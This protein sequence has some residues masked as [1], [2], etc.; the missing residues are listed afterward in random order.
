MIL[1][2]VPYIWEIFGNFFLHTGNFF[3]FFFMTGIFLIFFP[4]G[5]WRGGV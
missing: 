5:K 4:D 3:K 1:I 2:E